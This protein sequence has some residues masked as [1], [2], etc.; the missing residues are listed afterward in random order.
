MSLSISFSFPVFRGFF[1]SYSYVSFNSTSLAFIGIAGW[2]HLINA[3]YAICCTLYYEH[4]TIFDIFLLFHLKISCALC[5]RETSFIRFL[6]SI[7]EFLIHTSIEQ[8]SKPAHMEH[9]YRNYIVFY[10][11]HTY[12]GFRVFFCWILSEFASLLLMYV[13]KRLRMFLFFFTVSYI[14]SSIRASW[15]TTNY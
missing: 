13:H 6:Y 15:S 5:N 7:S 1:V 11:L 4:L 2:G 8:L 9:K 3:L 12:L 14:V 10:I